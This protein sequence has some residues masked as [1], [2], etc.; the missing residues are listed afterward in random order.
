MRDRLPPPTTT[1]A[2]V[3]TAAS[4][5]SGSPAGRANGVTPPMVIPVR[6][7]VSSA[8]A[9]DALRTSS[10]RRTTPLT[11]SRVVASTTQATWRGGSDLPATRIVLAE[12]SS[13]TPY[14]AQ[15]AAVSA[16]AGSQ[17]STSTLSPSGVATAI[18]RRR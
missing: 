5:H 15:N 18:A 4:I 1:D 16:S 7:A 8:P 2:R 6:A 9:N 17:G 13:A 12:S 3:I 14:A 10:R 11:S